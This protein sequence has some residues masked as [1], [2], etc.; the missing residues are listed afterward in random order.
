M[1]PY[2]YSCWLTL[3][4]TSKILFMII[5]SFWFPPQYFQHHGNQNNKNRG[6]CS[7][8]LRRCMAHKVSFLLLP[9]D[10]HCSLGHI[11]LINGYFLCCRCGRYI[12]L[13]RSEMDEDDCGYYDA[14]L[15]WSGKG[16]KISKKQELAKMSDGI[17]VSNVFLLRY[18]K[19]RFCFQKCR[20]I[21]LFLSRVDKLGRFWAVEHEKHGRVKL[22]TTRTPNFP[23]PRRTRC[24]FWTTECSKN[25]FEPSKYEQ[26]VA[27]WN[28]GSPRFT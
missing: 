6:S 14:D 23:F 3:F 1:S 22:P 27:P 10:S 4:S 24:E 11:P 26:N 16:Q 15:W 18:E 17:S 7:S 2:T 28:Y 21:W 25:F 13:L 9:T 8:L 20:Y 19:Y 12:V 5:R